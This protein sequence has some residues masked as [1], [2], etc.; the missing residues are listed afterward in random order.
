MD[1]TQHGGALTT[2]STT[3]NFLSGELVPRE[4]SLCVALG[5]CRA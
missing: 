1:K 2:I 3:I 5:Q 4:N